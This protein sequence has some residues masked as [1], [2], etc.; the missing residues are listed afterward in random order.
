MT[1]ILAGKR[2]YV[3]GGSSGIGAEI[4]RTF[5]AQ[6]AR[7][8]IGASSHAAQARE[9]ARSLPSAGGS[10]IVVQADF[11]DRAQTEQAA[12]AVLDGLGGLDIFVHSAGIDVTLTAPTHQT[13]DEVW[14]KM[15]TLHLT[16]AFRLSKQLI[17]ALLQGRNPSII[18]IG[19]VCGLVAWEGDVAYNVA[20]AGLQ[21]LARCIASDYAKSGLRANVIAPGVIDTPL[22]RSYA[23]GMPGGETEGLKTLA[24]MHPIGR[25]AQ[26]RE[27]AEAAAFLAS[28]KASFITGVVLPIDGGLTMV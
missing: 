24:A 11:Y 1:G 3:T 25:Y 8:A 19:S 16:A 15:M 5:A 12:D 13:T 21:H 14:D 6:G 28:D 7:V 22:T 18:F 4:V 9:T 27:I 10:H 23:G 20:K 26:P 2:A 17:P